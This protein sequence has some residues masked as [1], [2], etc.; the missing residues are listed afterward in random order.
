MLNA[1]ARC[2]FAINLAVLLLVGADAVADKHEDVAVEG[3][4]LVFRNVAECSRSE[5][6]DRI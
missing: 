4:L 6:M 1:D 5:F 2:D 3:T